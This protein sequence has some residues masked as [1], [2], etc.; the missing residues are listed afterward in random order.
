MKP[1]FFRS[2]KW[3]LQNEPTGNG[4][5]FLEAVS[6]EVLDRLNELNRDKGSGEGPWSYPWDPKHPI[7]FGDCNS[8]KESNRHM[9]FLCYHVLSI[10]HNAF[11]CVKNLQHLCVWGCSA[12][13]DYGQLEDL[14]KI[15][16]SLDPQ[17][18]FDFWMVVSFTPSEEK[19]R[20]SKQSES[21]DFLRKHPHMRCS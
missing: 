13:T 11:C 1:S 16:I 9:D 4:S 2:G 5:W 8:H 15:G 14:A 19:R 21:P 20:S 12:Y 17:F 3:L 7:F 6:E 10:C 18:N